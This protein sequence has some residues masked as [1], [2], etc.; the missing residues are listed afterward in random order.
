[1]HD[2]LA[3]IDNFTLKFQD[4]HDVRILMVCLMALAISRA[5][6]SQKN[7]L[8]PSHETCHFRFRIVSTKDPVKL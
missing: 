1:M 5:F 6:I 4:A 8:L 7:F 2:L 3:K